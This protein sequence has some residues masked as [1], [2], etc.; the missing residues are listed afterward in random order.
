MAG[1]H[2]LPAAATTPT[3][4]MADD[5]RRRDTPRERGA[6]EVEAVAEPI[7]AI[8]RDIQTG[9]LTPRASMPAIKR[10]VPLRDAGDLLTRLA[11]AGDPRAVF[12]A[13][14][15][16]SRGIR[17]PDARE[18]ALESML[19]QGGW[20]P[21]CRRPGWSRATAAAPSSRCATG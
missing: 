18:D 21:R 5:A 12:R 15:P 10:E 13:L 8:A 3:A 6:I 1:A 4:L 14:A 9:M 11:D 16:Q 20:G 2:G 17:A 7:P 19:A